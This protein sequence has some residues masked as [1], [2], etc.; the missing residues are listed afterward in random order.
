MRLLLSQQLTTLKDTTAF[1]E[2]VAPLFAPGGVLL[3]KGNLGAGKTTFVQA[4]ARC[5]GV[6][7]TVTSPTFTLANEYPIPGG[8]RL[9]HCD[10]YRLASPDGFYDLGLD[11][12]LERGDRLAI[13]WPERAAEILDIEAPHRLVLTLELQADGS[14][15]AMLHEEMV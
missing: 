6:T 10:L 9:V 11:E 5:Y 1:A 14:R 12:A 7:R 8:G 4:L 15:L 2:A 13:E 3:L